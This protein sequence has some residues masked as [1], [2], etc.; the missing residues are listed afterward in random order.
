LSFKYKLPRKLASG[1]F[2][3]NLRGCDLSNVL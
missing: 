3:D 2:L 1:M